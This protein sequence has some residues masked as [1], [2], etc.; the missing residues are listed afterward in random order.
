MKPSAPE[1]L[2]SRRPA[3][4]TTSLTTMQAKPAP[5]RQTTAPTGVSRLAVPAS[6][7]PTTRPI[8]A[9]SRVILP[10]ADPWVPV[11]PGEH[12]DR[13][14][15]AELEADAGEKPTGENLTLLALSRG[16]GTLGGMSERPTR[17]TGAEPTP[18]PATWSA[19]PGC[20]RSA[21]G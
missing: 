2:P 1:P 5:S 6:R 4:L 19:T 13:D 14:A 20:S 11:V 17:P 3:P 15:D 10:R 12:P 9:A 16:F 21:P 18:A 8:T 7:K